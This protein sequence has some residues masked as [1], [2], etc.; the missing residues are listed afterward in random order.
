M[1][2]VRVLGGQ[3]WH[4]SLDDVGTEGGQQAAQEGDHVAEGLQCPQ[5]HL[6]ISVC[7]SRVEGIKHLVREKLSEA[8]DSEVNK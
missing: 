1:Q 4:E 8:Y 5:V 7:Q 3:V 2:Y 6:A